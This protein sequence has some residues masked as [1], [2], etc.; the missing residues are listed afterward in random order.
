MS[1]ISVK[2]GKLFVDDKQFDMSEVRRLSDDELESVGG[3][4]KIF[5]TGTEDN[6]QTE[7]C[8]CCGSDIDWTITNVMFE[9]EES[10]LVL[11]CRCG[12]STETTINIK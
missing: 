1:K 6:L 2:N 11:K 8:L 7:K 12:Y 4:I 10:Y 5:T 9:L 3:G